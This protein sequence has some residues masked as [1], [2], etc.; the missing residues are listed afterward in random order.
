MDMTG[1]MT[2]FIEDAKRN[3][4]NIINQLILECPGIDINLGFIGYREIGEEYISIEFTKEYEQLKYSIKNVYASGGQGDGPEDVAWAMEEATYKNWQNNAR[5]IILI[6]DYP[7]HGLKYHNLKKDL[8]PNGAPNRRNIEELIK[9]LAE[10]NISLFCLKI[11]QFT[12]KMFNIFN[13]IYKNYN[14]CEFKVVPMSSG[15]LTNVV[16]NSAAEVYVSQR[17]IDI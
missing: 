17:N 1:S 15:G 14:K 13:D 7:C 11:T 8:Y 4:I 3:I 12:D 5:F 6:A 16:V 2:D 10:N 9:E